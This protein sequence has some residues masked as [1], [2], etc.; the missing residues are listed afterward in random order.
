MADTKASGGYPQQPVGYPQQQPSAPP[1]YSS[2][3]GSTQ[4][5]V[6]YG[7][8]QGQP[9]AQSTVVVTTVS[10]VGFPFRDVPVSMQCPNC[11]NHITST[12]IFESGLLVWLLVL[13]I[14]FLLQLW[15]GCCLIPFFIDDLKDVRHVCPVCNYQL[16]VYKRL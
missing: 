12:C 5:T 10:H 13:G 15:L 14:A 11:H 4:P 6:Y 1:P 2:A 9:T 3:A 16:G 8:P 7:P